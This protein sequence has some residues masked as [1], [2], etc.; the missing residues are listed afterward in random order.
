MTQPLPNT[1]LDALSELG[2]IEPHRATPND[3]R[4]CEAA[5]AA[6]DSS[7]HFGIWLEARAILASFLFEDR[8]GDRSQNINRATGIYRDILEFNISDIYPQ[9]WEA[10]VIGFGNC[11]MA[12]PNSPIEAFQHGFALLD[13][14]VA[15][16]R[17]GPDPE[18]LAVA[19]SCYGN[20][21]MVS[22]TGSHDDNLVHA[23]ALFHE[24]IEVL[25]SGDRYPVRWARAHHNLGRLYAS[26]RTGE[27]S[28][29]VDD[30]IS[31]LRVALDWRPRDFDPGGRA[32]TLRALALLLPEWSGADSLADAN[33]MAE[34]C[35]REAADI[36]QGDPRATSGSATWGPLAG[37]RSA[38]NVD[39]DGYLELPPAEAKLQLQQVIA[40]HRAAIAHLSLDGEPSQWADWKG[41]LGQ[42]L[43]RLAHMEHSHSAANEACKHLREAIAV[44]SEVSHP[45][46][47]R[48]L[49]RAIGQLGHQ[50]GSWEHS[51]VGYASALALSD[52]LFD[53]AAAPDSRRQELVD[54]RGFA[55]FAAYGAAREGKLDD[56]IRLAEHGRIR[57]LIETVSTT[58]LLSSRASQELRD[59]L[60]EASRRVAHLE[61]ELR[62]VEEND[63]R[64]VA[65]KMT[66]RLAGTLGLPPGLLKVRVTS[67]GTLTD[68]VAA[69]Y[70]RIT[71]ELHL[72]RARLRE[73]IN[74][75]RE[76]QPGIGLDPLDAQSIRAVASTMQCPLIYLLATVHGAVALIV[77]PDGNLK[78]LRFDAVTSNLL[79]TLLY[80]SNETDGYLNSSLHGNVSALAQSLYSVI[81]TLAEVLVLP[82]AD[83]L[84]TL[85]HYRAVIVPLGNMGLLPL[86]AAAPDTIALGY[87]PSARALQMAFR[88]VGRPVDPKPSLLAVGNPSRASISG[89]PLAVAEARAIA[90]VAT[91]WSRA[92]VFVGSDAR[93]EK[94]HPETG[95]VT[96]IHFACHGRFQQFQPLDSALLLAEDDS[97][98]LD[99]L[100][101][102]RVRLSSARLAV[103][104]ACHSANVEP[105]TLPDE[106]LGLPTGLLLAGVPSVVGTMWPVDERVGTLFSLRF[107][108]ELDAGLD[109]LAAVASAQRWLRD[110]SAEQLAARATHM[111]TL[112]LPGDAE[113]GAALSRLWREL[114]SHSPNDRPFAS[115]VYW[116]TFAY[117]GV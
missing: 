104:C 111:R 59:T 112:L 82:L 60:T 96:H 87:A 61:A 72:A 13:N 49:H 22:P 94:I 44:A 35:W 109:P 116:A 67:Q 26:R 93:L 70:L 114:V 89:L 53:E 43:A 83:W 34:A 17:R 32:R 74:T 113:A 97:I 75:A 14:L 24:E 51:H 100:F 4:R 19:L 6:I 46:L 27:R 71:S 11:L 9:V 5:L 66:N 10:A 2:A 58:A 30:A 76:G 108:E 39:L 7:A 56:A 106:M 18:R 91:R 23:R 85:K 117:V 1:I 57:S 88:F 8:E 41:G 20:V 99:D 68:D 69:D 62:A 80:G 12:N 31:A 79:Q 52:R 28:Q 21:L 50:L 110:S 81:K 33:A 40:N 103:L 48:D 77:P 47:C 65:Q 86:H 98:S 15:F 25:G 29:N 84:T 95:S 64:A 63:S 38:L 90:G 92:S 73:S 45:R 55:Q 115:P 16:L 107:Y 3:M 42:L 37:E 101:A 105:Y 36:A 54:M 78:L 102:G